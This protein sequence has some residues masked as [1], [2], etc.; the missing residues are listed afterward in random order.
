MYCVSHWS[1]KF[2]D[3][4]ACVILMFLFSDSEDAGLLLILGVI[5]LFFYLLFC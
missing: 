1:R 5:Y 3:F 2:W 4:F